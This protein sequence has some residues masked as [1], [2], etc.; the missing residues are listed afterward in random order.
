MNPAVDLS[1]TPVAVYVRLSKEDVSGK[2]LGIESTGVQLKDAREAIAREGWSLPDRHVFVDDGVSGTKVNRSAWQ[3]MLAAA[4]RGEFSA[5]VVRDLDRFSRLDPVRTLSVIRD[6]AD[7]GVAL[8]S[9]RERQY[10]SV[11]G[12]QVIITTVRARQAAAEAEKASQRITAGLRARAREGRATGRAPFGYRILMVT[13]QDL[14]DGSDRRPGRWWVKHEPEL[15]VVRH[16]VQL[17]LAT[18]S[19]TATT[20]RLNAD[21]TRPPKGASW[22]AISSVKSLLRQPLYRGYR[23][24]KGERVD[25]PELALLADAEVKRLETALERVSRNRPW[26]KADRK[27]STFNVA[28]PF[29]ACGVCKGS[30]VASGSG[31]KR[32]YLCDRHR[33]KA[34]RGVGYRSA[35]RVDEAIVRAV[36]ATLTPEA[37]AAVCALVRDEV[38]SRPRTRENEHER[39]MREISSTEKRLENLDNSLAEASK[40]E[41]R[42]RAFAKMEAEMDRLRALRTS[43]TYLEAKPLELDARRTVANV[44]KRALELRAMLAK[45]G[46][47]A[48]DAIRVVLGSKRL[49]AHLVTV[50]GRRGWKLSGRIGGCYVLDDAHHG[51]DTNLKELIKGDVTGVS[52]TPITTPAA[53]VAAPAPAPTPVAQPTPSPSPSAPSPAPS[54]SG[55]GTTTA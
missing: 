41:L 40:P 23:L 54:H 8:W 35:A 9:Y 12:D 24:H 55:G 49:Q 46:R 36:A 1:A 21:G 52:V 47:D 44:Q 45:G 4:Q 28:V 15:A 37:I 5:I 50:E 11:D 31:S 16:V 27:S 29:V 53:P 43:L 30:I 13:D 19:L 17:F 20:H 39:L 33:M 7:A 22:G 25:H 38:E 14:R 18:E 32:M 2:R 34:C 26:A 48:A 42:A 6:L 10:I 51:S 3:A